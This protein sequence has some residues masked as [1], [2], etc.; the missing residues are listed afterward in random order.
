MLFQ[1]AAFAQRTHPEL[2]LL[3][4]I[5]NSGGYSGGFRSNAARV[6]KSKRSGTKKGVPDVCLP[7]ARG[8]YH[9]LYVELKAGKNKPSAEQQEWIA[10]LSEHGNAAHVCTGWEAAR[11]VILNYLAPPAARR[12]RADADVTTPRPSR[13][14]LR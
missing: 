12:S 13:S 2:A 3:F 7:V 1:W 11:D 9:A 10:A 5:P 8:P 4:A 14:S 6:V